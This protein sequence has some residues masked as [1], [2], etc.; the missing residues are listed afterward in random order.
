MIQAKVNDKSQF[1]LIIQ[2]KKLNLNG[3]SLEFDSIN[4][5]DGS[6]HLLLKHRS[7]T[8]RLRKGN[9]EEKNYTLSVNGRVYEV[10]LQDEMDLLLKKMGFSLAAGKKVNDLKAPMPGLVL[11]VNVQVGDAVKK[12]DSL[13]VLEAMKMENSLKSPADA[14]I[15]RIAV[16]PGDKVEKNQ[17]LLD[18]E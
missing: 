11:K 13:L 3:K 2:D 1:D 18:F 12:G 10:S 8:V 14:I 6:L 9:A 7:Y 16:N 4:L 15:K 17:V 5:Q